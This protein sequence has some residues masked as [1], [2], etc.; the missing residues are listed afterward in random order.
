MK[1]KLSNNSL[2]QRRNFLKKLSLGVG[3]AS[4]LAMQGKLQLMQSA[5]A[6]SSNYDFNDHKSLVCVFLYGGN[7]SFN[8]LVP[9]EQAAYQQYA[10]SRNDMALNRD[11]LLALKG[12]D[13]A[14][15]ASMPELKALYNADKLGVVANVGAL[16]E[17]VTKLAY[18]NK[19]ARLPANLFSHSHQQEF[20]ETGATAKNSVHP[21]G[22]GGRM[23]DMLASANTNSEKA[24]LFSVAGNSIWQ[25]G[26][27]PLDFVLNADT[28]VTKLR[29]FEKNNWPIWRDGRIAAWDNIKE[30]QSPYLLSQQLTETFKQKEERISGIADDIASAPEIIT[31]FA[32][33]KLSKQLKVVAKMIAIRENLGMKRQIF[34]VGISGWDNHGNQLEDHA[35]RLSELDAALSSFYKS[36]VELNVA[37]SVTAF[38]ASEFGRTYSI[39][40]D[41]TDHAWSGHSLI[42]GGAVKGGQIH[43]DMPD[44]TLGGAD[45][46]DT[47]GRFI[48][49]Y[50]VDQY[51]ATVAKWM[52]MTD[53]D[54]LDIFPNLDNF[55]DKS[56]G[57]ML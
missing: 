34:F 44:F 20:W 52:G 45:D 55:N 41:G 49:K 27:N 54:N 43:G 50:S 26:L 6:A 17:P 7:Y 15:H 32:A 10:E 29:A 4:L 22:W 3:S 40:G 25:R 11:S 47:T 35:T 57:F 1:T 14:F 13:Y 38:T 21:P 30:M 42:M 37:D 2:Q 12:N 39:N 5:I 19:T 56:L 33:D 46:T 53:S 18:E 9:Y 36:T 24:A 23:M 16:I 8:M 48:P 31:S 28:G 51:G